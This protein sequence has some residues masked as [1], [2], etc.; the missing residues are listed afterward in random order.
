MNSSAIIAAISFFFCPLLCRS[1]NPADEFFR[2]NIQDVRRLVAAY[3]GP[4]VR[5]EGLAIANGWYVTAKPHKPLG[6]DIM[7]SASSAFLPSG[8]RYFTFIPSEYRNVG[9][10]Q[11]GEDRIPTFIGHD[12]PGPALR[13]EAGGA[14]IEFHLPEGVDMPQWSGKTLAYMPVI[15]AGLGL[16]AGTD[17]KFRYW[18]EIQI[19]RT[20]N[21]GTGAAIMHDAGQWIPFLKRLDV[22]VSLLAGFTRLHSSYDFAGDHSSMNYESLFDIKSR[23]IQAIV[24]KEFS[25]ISIFA[26]GGW[27]F[28][29]S[30]LSYEGE[31]SLETTGGQILY[32]TIRPV[33]VSLNYNSPLAAAG[34]RVK[35][36]GM[37]VHASVGLAKYPFAAAGIGV[38]IR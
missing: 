22:H 32:G 21:K 3:A 9:L 11:G 4:F 29:H 15:Q 6:F 2:D 12:R 17:L 34:F 14:A 1:Q 25:F 10:A 23:T 35:A 33:S 24:S 18:P 31:F 26:G 16:I 36:A 5:G 38:D 37:F 19:G 8:E 27:Y 20:R 30:D 13:A 7:A 28:I